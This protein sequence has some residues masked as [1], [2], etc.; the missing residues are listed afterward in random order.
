MGM[1]MYKSTVMI[2]VTQ[3]VKQTV[4]V[5]AADANK[6]KKQIDASVQLLDERKLRNSVATS[7]ED[8]RSAVISAK[9]NKVAPQKGK[10]RP[11]LSKVQKQIIKS[12]LKGG[13]SSM[14][15]FNPKNGWQNSAESQSQ[16]Y[17]RHVDVRTIIALRERNLIK[18][19]AVD[20]LE[21]TAQQ[22]VGTIGVGEFA[23]VLNMDEV[24][25]RKVYHDSVRK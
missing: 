16:S 24:K 13:T 6:A 10:K 18:P 21:L 8:L 3:R 5:F 9:P 14:L 25:K 7:G 19:F 1:E 17:N 15:T 2:D 11:A 23:F 22:A 4:Y 12:M 20:E